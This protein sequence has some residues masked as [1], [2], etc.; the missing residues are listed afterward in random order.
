VSLV[1]LQPTARNVTVGLI[2]LGGPSIFAAIV[3]GATLS[4]RSSNEL[5]VFLGAVLPLAIGLSV[6]LARYR[7]MHL[8]L[9][10]E[11]NE[12]TFRNAWT[13]GVFT[14]SE[15][16]TFEAKE[17][18]LGYWI[19]VARLRN[20]RTIRLCAAPYAKF[21]SLAKEAGSGGAPDGTALPWH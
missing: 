15:V 13:S 3:L 19:A 14:W 5:I 10:N 1:K 2:E 9:D 12:I 4:D 20:N 6:V 7:P 11:K 18:Y 21:L 16:Q 17:K 8:V